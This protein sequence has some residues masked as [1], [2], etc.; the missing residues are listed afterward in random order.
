MSPPDQSTFYERPTPPAKRSAPALIELKKVRREFPAGDEVVVA[1]KDVSLTI[2]HGEMVAI[3]GSS[4]SGKSTLMNI[5]GCLDRPTSGTYRV[6]GRDTRDMAPAN[7][8]DTSRSVASSSASLLPKWKLM[9]AA[10]CPATL[11][12]FAEVSSERPC[13]EIAATVA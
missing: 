5:L 6:L 10:V 1:L 8:S 9:D 3:V 4:G 12:I 2:E 7:S 13:W 11:A